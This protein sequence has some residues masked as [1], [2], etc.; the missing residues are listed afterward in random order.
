MGKIITAVT[1]CLIFFLSCGQVYAEKI[2]GYSA[3]ITYNSESRQENIPLSVKKLA[4]KRVLN[5]YNSPLNEFSEQF[6]LTC[7]KYKLDCY[8][9]PS[10]AGVESTFGKFIYPNS[11]NSFGWGGGKIM[12][13]NWSM[14][15]DEVGKGLRLNYVDKGAQS[16]ESIGKIYCG[17]ESW[18]K[19]IRYFMSEF[20]A[21]EQ[22]IQLFLNDNTVQL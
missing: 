11:H 2:A 18:P 17:S 4:I 5:R 21:E 15:I 19:K 20:I 16:I 8:L 10:I 1:I 7:L 22:K 12:F 3:N 6:I 14:A 13:S 9:L